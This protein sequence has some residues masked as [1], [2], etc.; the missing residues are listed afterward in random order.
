MEI[1]RPICWSRRME[2]WNWVAVVGVA[3]MVDL[4]PWDANTLAV[5]IIGIWW[6]PPTKGK[7]KISKTAGAPSDS[8]TP[9][10]REG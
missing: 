7:K 8:M 6:P 1:W 3:K 4:T 5:S 9:I 10:Q 2:F